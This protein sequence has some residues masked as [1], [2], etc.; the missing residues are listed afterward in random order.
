[1]KLLNTIFLLM[2]FL[3]FPGCAQKTVGIGQ[4]LEAMPTETDSRAA[5]EASLLAVAEQAGVSDTDALAA[6]AELDKVYDETSAQMSEAEAQ[7]NA[8]MK[9]LKDEACID[10]CSSD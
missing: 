6:K 10:D 4:Q 7:R 8:R 3:I 9:Q 5:D 2:G 1:M